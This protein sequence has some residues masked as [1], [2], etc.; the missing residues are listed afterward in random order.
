MKKSLAFA[1][2]TLLIV[3]S[4]FSR[5]QAGAQSSM[6]ASLNAQFTSTPITVDG[7]PE[8]AWNN[9]TASPIK[10]CMNPGL[11]APLTNCTASGTVQ[12]MWN[13]PLLYLLFRVSDPDVT[14]ASTTATNRS[15]VQIFVDQYDDK[16]PKFEEDD[17]TITISAAGQQ[18]GNATNAGL[19]IYPT[20]WSYHLK[21]YAAALTTSQGVTNGYNIEVAWY[22]GDRPLTNGTKIGMDFDIYAASSAT[23][24]NLSR[25]FWSSGSNKGTDSNTMWGDIVL[26]GYD[27]TSAMQLN[28]FMLNVNVAKAKG[29]VRGIWTDETALN[30]ALITATNVQGIPTSQAQIDS[31]N[32]AL[33]TALR[34]LRRKGKYPDPYDLPSTVPLNDPFTFFDG[35]KVKTLADWNKRRAE[36]KDMAQYYE[37]GYM[38]G[39][40]QSLTATS[41]TASGYN[42]VG[43]SMGDGGRT[44]SFNARLTLPPAGS[45]KSAPY[46]VIVQLD[47][48]PTTGNTTYTNAGYAVLSIPVG[49]YPAFGFPGIASDDGNHTGTYFNL[50]P[51]DVASGKDAGVLMAWA[52]GAS[53]GV[54]ALKYLAVN[55]SAYA[56]LLDL[57]RLVVT[58]FSRYGKAALVAGFLDDRFQV[59]APGGSGSGGAAPYRYDSFGNTP[60]RT[61]ATLGNV[62]PWGQSPGAEVLG[63][64]VR[65]QTHNSNEMIRRF[66]NDTVPAAVEPRMYKTS[67][68]GYGN[69]M[70]F[71]HHEEIAAIAP[72]AVLIDNTNDDYA[73]NAEGDS[74]GY[75][76]AMPVYAY[77]GAKQNLALD[78]YMG[79]GGH[80]LKSSQAQDIIAFSDFVLYG[81]PLS[82]AVNTQLTTDPYLKAGT[83]DTYYGGLNTMMPWLTSV[84]HANSLTGLSVSAGTLSPAFNQDTTNYS[85]N[86]ANAVASTT[87]TATAEDPNA[88]I[89]VNGQAITSGQVSASLPVGIGYN[90]F[91][92]SVTAVDGA[93]KTYQIVINRNGVATTTAV[94]SS[95][96]NSNLNASVTLTAN[97][98]ATGPS[99][100]LGTV[101]FM[102]G[103]TV[104]GTGNLTATGATASRATL[105]VS[106]LSAGTHNIAAI[107]PGMYGFNSSTSA[108]ISQVV[109]APAI[110][111]AFSPTA[112]TVARGSSGTSTLTLTPVGGFTGAVTLTC[113]TIGVP[114]NMSC[115]FSPASVTFT[116]SSSAQTST[117]TIGTTAVAELTQPTSPFAR[118]NARTELAM[119]SLPCVG[120]L[121]MLGRRRARGRKLTLLGVLLVCS[122]GAMT[123]ISGCASGG[124]SKTV[125]GSYVIPVNVTAGGSTQPVSLSVTVQ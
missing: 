18:T 91:S 67:T 23:R 19:T 68:P 72:R 8:A 35:T 122:L 22:I 99:A 2:A 101:T 123:A 65:H 93:V 47:I 64:H 119:L 79:G 63:D 37:F 52:W 75:E 66:L 13:G 48:F 36:L 89:T 25:V 39:T 17:S 109:T 97:V 55:N 125:A 82:S 16:F 74:I 32:L 120:L 9:A 59:T 92:V 115:G 33:D 5:Q 12:A 3:S 26:A 73:D 124:D 114:Q 70:P 100:P 45:A 81:A 41:T 76:G 111:A 88:T 106:T 20:S 105:A 21:S 117:I 6:N 28:D 44:A 7:V 107:Y 104:L 61:S 27:G 60:Y 53:R 43:V 118:S 50:Y 62:Y 54:D 94:S 42:T 49:D 40:P 86:V 116:G 96:L 29:L 31:A 56:N 110:Q 87:V 95:A 51:Y 14:T 83:Y 84:P 113:G 102:D 4:M 85:F 71:D 10:I 112:I 121:A 98:T 57:N 24:T 15:S 90:I 78:L 34:G 38:P 30:S 58:G 77:L 80:S 1:T 69:R 46:P 11:T 108:S 103:S